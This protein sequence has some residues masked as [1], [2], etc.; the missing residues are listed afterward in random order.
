M[1]HIV[2]AVNIVL[3][4]EDQEMKLSERT[5]EESY[6]A[7]SNVTE[8]NPVELS[9]LDFFVHAMSYFEEEAKGKLSPEGQSQ[10]SS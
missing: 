2:N 8:A 3:R 6:A 1:D 7:K 9:A 5:D 10:A 4:A